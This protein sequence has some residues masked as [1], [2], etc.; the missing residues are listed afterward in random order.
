[1]HSHL[2]RRRFS[3]K[4]FYLPFKKFQNYLVPYYIWLHL[5]ILTWTYGEILVEHST[6]N[7]LSPANWSTAMTS[8]RQNVRKFAR[9]SHSSAA[10]GSTWVLKILT[11]F[12]AM[13]ENCIDNIMENRPL[14]KEFSSLF[15]NVGHLQGKLPVVRVYTCEKDQVPKN[16]FLKCHIVYNGK[17]NIKAKEVFCCLFIG[18]P[19]VN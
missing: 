8:M 4:C 9:W 14:F 16:Q 5:T 7:K 2:C 18:Y 19:F 13:R 3:C 6:I 12:P 15:P 1:M 10:R 11:L 17:Q